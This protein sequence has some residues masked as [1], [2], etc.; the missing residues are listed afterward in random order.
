LLMWT[1][2]PLD[3]LEN[4]PEEVLFH[5]CIYPRLGRNSIRSKLFVVLIFLDT[6]ILLCTY[7]SIF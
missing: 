3:A 1:S 7:I 5:V 2:P 4:G 6:L